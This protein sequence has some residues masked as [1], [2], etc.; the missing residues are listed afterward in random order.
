MC[1]DGTPRD[2]Q[3]LSAGCAATSFG[4]RQGHSGI[5]GR[6]GPRCSAS[7]PVERMRTSGAPSANVT[8]CECDCLINPPQNRFAFSACL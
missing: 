1:N 2:R 7:R 6:I 5:G 4:A 3:G 8:G